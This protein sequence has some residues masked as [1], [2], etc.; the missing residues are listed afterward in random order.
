[1]TGEAFA[2]SMTTSTHTGTR[3]EP[4]MQ[5]LS[6]ISN[7]VAPKA[8]MLAGGALVAG[9]LTEIVHSQRHAGNNVVGVAGYLTLSFFVVALICVAPSFLA[10]ARRARP[11]IAQK[12]A[13]AAAAGTLVLGVTSI[14]SLVNGSDLAIFNV[15]APIT[16]AAW[17]FGSIVLAVALKRSGR[18][19]TFVAVGLPVAWVATV[20]LATVGGGVVSGA[21]Y[22]AVGYLLANDALERRARTAIQPAAL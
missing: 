2:A 14:A 8:T 22:L 3:K 7:K 20:P 18:V 6:S 10:L 4:R 15:I 11:G 16:N 13:V 19:S 17:L 1:M 21:Y 5:K 9:G 12:A